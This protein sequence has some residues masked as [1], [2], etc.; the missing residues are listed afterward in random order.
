[1]GSNFEV[2]GFDSVG[3]FVDAMKESEDAWSDAFVEFIISSGLADELRSQD[4]ESFARQYNGTGYKTNKY[5]SKL[6]AAYRKFS[7]QKAH[8]G[9]ASVGDN[10]EDTINANVSTA[11]SDFNVDGG[12]QTKQSAPDY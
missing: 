9:F 11:D 2:A 8:R 7:K 5:D 12:D 4:W 10:S 6:A 3:E 1:M